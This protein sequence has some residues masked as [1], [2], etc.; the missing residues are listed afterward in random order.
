[1]NGYL[2]MVLHAHLPFVYHPELD[3]ALEEN[4]L[5]EAMTETYIPLLLM[6]EKLR[7][8]NITFKIT[9]SLSPTLLE[10]FANPILSYRFIRR[11]DRLIDLAEKET[12]RTANNEQLHQLALLH[13]KRIISVKETFLYSFDKDL[14]LQFK[15][16]QDDGYLEILG[17]TA[18]HG[19]L[20]LLQFDE[21]AVESQIK[22]GLDYYQNV[23]QVKP[24]GMWLPE[25]GY[26]R[27]LEKYLASNGIRFCFLETHGITRGEPS[28][29]YGVYEPVTT[30]NG[31]SFFGRDPD[32]S[33]LVWS[34]EEG[35]PANPVY[36][37][38]YRD[39]AYDLDFDYLKP[40]INSP[41]L[42]FDSGFK[43][44][45]ITGKT[46]QKEYYN[47]C[48]A[49]KKLKEHAVDFV[50]KKVEQTSQLLSEMDKKPIVVAPF[51]AE[52]FGHWWGEG[53]EWL[54]LVLREIAAI[55]EK[56][57]MVCVSSYLEDN[58]E[59]FSSLPASSSWG[60]NGYNKVWLN[61][62]NEWIYRHLHHGANEL[63]ESIKVNPAA[64][65]LIK[66]GL[67]QAMRELL[68]AQSSDWAFMVGCETTAEYGQKR[69]EN[70]ILTLNR[71][72]SS[73][74]NGEIEE[75]W[76]DMVESMHSS[77]RNIDYRVFL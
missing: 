27:G 6:F 29:R 20:P 44:F 18:T 37:E 17:S 35:Y 68:L 5:F 66:R 46:E 55:P 76:L 45:R 28:P 2:A 33:R 9:V 58:P 14:T 11:L 31:V 25:C 77:F 64:S 12:Q 51:D 3:D 41:E 26:Y 56:I 61:E 69:I 50:Q 72:L 16:L 63:R 60:A 4:W 42:R 54:N 71:L 74:K 32:S 73:I 24:S 21:G 49:E 39:I 62:K 47:S 48:E 75:G 22:I 40:F 8:D 65:G 30:E 43:Y 23:F 15:K 52:L 36:R 67:Q 13:Q 53:V 1:M 19:Y 57:S 10:M 38:F 34:A 59:S 7:Q 70:H